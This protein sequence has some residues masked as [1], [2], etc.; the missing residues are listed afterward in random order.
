MIR[1]QASNIIS[2]TPKISSLGGRGGGG[3]AVK[4]LYRFSWQFLKLPQTF[5]IVTPSSPTFH[6]GPAQ[7]GHLELTTG[8]HL[9]QS[10]VLEGQ[11]LSRHQT[12][13]VYIQLS[14]LDVTESPAEEQLGRRDGCR[15]LQQNKK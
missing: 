12:D 6:G 2:L 1:Y 5:E 10:P 11:Q 13:Q 8:G 14:A 3:G 4:K 15:Q 7:C 9:D